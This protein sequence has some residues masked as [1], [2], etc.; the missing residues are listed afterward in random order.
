MYRAFLNLGSKINA[1]NKDE[2]RIRC[3]DAVT[4]RDPVLIVCCLF[5][6]VQVLLYVESFEI[7]EGC[8]DHLLP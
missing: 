3:F 4:I 2:D 8:C 6:M 5:V 1:C 7:N